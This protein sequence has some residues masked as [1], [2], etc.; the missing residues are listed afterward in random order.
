[1]SVSISQVCT[2]RRER[3]DGAWFTTEGRGRF[4]LGT[5]NPNY[6]DFY[7]FMARPR[8]TM[9]R[10]KGLSNPDRCKAARR[11]P[12]G[13]PEGIYRSVCH[14]LLADWWRAIRR[15]HRRPGRS[16]TEEYDFPTV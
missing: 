6:L 3:P 15:H 16:T 4:P 13:H 14:D 7:R 5:G 2:R 8:Q 1:M 9:T 11:V 12:T 10:G